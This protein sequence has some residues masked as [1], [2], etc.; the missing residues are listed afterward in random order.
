[1]HNILITICIFTLGILLGLLFAKLFK[2][3]NQE[4][5]N[6]IN[7]KL[8][9]MKH[10]SVVDKS[11]LLTV[12]RREIANYLIS[13]DPQRFLDLYYRI[14]EECSIIDEMDNKT[15]DAQALV[16][17]NKYPYF[18]DFDGF[19]VHEFVLYTDAMEYQTV[20]ELEQKYIDNCMFQHIES[21]RSNKEYVTL[22]ELPILGDE[23]EKILLKKIDK[24]KGK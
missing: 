3:K 4:T 7:F 22:N 14:I 23:K 21:I 12:Y 10:N 13:V 9:E 17:S 2:S 6:I 16:L 24:Y 5:S 8:N 11:D 18:K 1:M 15:R 19:N 20:E